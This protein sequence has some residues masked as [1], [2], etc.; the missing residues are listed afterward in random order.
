MKFHLF[1][2]G[3]TAIAASVCPAAAR[4]DR[5]DGPALSRACAPASPSLQQ[6][7]VIVNT[8]NDD[9]NCLSA[10]VDRRANITALRFE[11]H[12][13]TIDP[14]SGRRVTRGV[15]VRELTPHDIGS[16]KGA[17]LDGRPGHD[18]VILHGEIVAGRSTQTLVIEFLHNG[19]TN[20]FRACPVALD[21]GPHRAW[22][23]VDA[24]NAPVPLVVVKTWA[25]PVIGTVGIATLQGICG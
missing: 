8:R 17:V 7:A 20:E 24:H 4:N 11:A 9:Y 5:R 21:R 10:S 16:A 18:A 23:L 19:L 3:L 22:H 1:A 12:K 6:L 2:L 14:V 15:R 25:L 13:V